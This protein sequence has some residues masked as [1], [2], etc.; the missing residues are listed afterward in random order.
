MPQNCD[1][2]I[3]LYPSDSDYVTAKLQIKIQLFLPDGKQGAAKL[4]S[5]PSQML[6]GSHGPPQG[7]AVL[8]THH[9]S[10][11]AAPALLAYWQLLDRFMSSSALYSRPQSVLTSEE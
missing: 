10:P 6:C 7:S 11:P 9:L 3:D 2:S 4:G 5:G 8:T 1:H